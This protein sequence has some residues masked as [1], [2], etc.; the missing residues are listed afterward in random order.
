MTPDAIEAEMRQ[1]RDALAKLGRYPHGRDLPRSNALMRRLL[2]LWAWKLNRE[3][4][5]AR[6]DA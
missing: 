1:A 6:R 4:Q 5:Q 3:A 2:A